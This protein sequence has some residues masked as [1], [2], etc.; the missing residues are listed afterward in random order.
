MLSITELKQHLQDLTP[1]EQA[2]L[3]DYLGTL[4]QASPEPLHSIWELRGLGAEI[5]Q[6]IDAQAYV[7][8]LRREW[9]DRP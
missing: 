6:G 8:D 4:L 7:D 9:D 5:W 3:R 2:E 1:D